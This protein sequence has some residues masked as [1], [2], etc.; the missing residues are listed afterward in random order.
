MLI[1]VKACRSMTI[2]AP[3]IPL[4][5]LHYSSLGLGSNLS[6]ISVDVRTLM[7][8]SGHHTRSTSRGGV[9]TLTDCGKVDRVGSY[10]ISEINL[11][12]FN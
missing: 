12:N 5:L 10:N 1:I 4:L 6:G 7:P 8:Y 2:F 9:D 3:P 11:F